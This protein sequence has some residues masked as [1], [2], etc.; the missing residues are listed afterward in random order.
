MEQGENQ[1]FSLDMPVIN[2][3]TMKMSNLFQSEGEQWACSPLPFFHSI[4]LTLAFS[5]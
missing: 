1:K 2:T 5:G 4:L 3:N